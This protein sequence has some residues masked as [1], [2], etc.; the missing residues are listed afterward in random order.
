MTRLPA[1]IAALV[2][3]ATAVSA[4]PPKDQLLA[5]VERDLPFYVPGVDVAS[6]SRHQIASLHLIL[7]GPH[8]ASHKQA[9]IRSVLGGQYSLRSLLFK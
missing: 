2:L 5:G 4:A 3:S 6:L 7:H 1:L 8:R 9:M